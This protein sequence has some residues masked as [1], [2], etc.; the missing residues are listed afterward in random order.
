MSILYEDER[1]ICDE[2][3]IRIKDCYKPL[4]GDKTI[5]YRDI[6]SVKIKKLNPLAGLSQIWGKAGDSLQ[7]TSASKRYWFTFD[8][9]RVFKSKAI[10]IDEGNLV[11]S[12]ITP[13][14]VERVFDIL[15][16][17]TIASDTEHITHS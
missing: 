5:L 6:R 4:G 12:A 16:A 8:L 15:Q 9:K 10:V 3:G 11:R 7:D 1:V 13:D 14:D 2:S 17:Q